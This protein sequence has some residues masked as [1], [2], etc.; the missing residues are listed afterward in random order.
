[1]NF[2]KILNKHLKLKKVIFLREKIDFFGKNLKQT[3]PLSI[4]AYVK[5]TK[6][7]NNFLLKKTMIY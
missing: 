5:T 7:N 6:N 1:M 2:L 3:G 4:I